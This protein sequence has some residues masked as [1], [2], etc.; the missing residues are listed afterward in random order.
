MDVLSESVGQAFDRIADQHGSKVLLS[1][2]EG[3]LTYAEAQWRSTRLAQYLRSNGL[4]G[5]E[6]VGVAS[7]DMALMLVAC[8]GI[9]KAGGAYVPLDPAL[10]D[11]RLHM[12]MKT[13]GIGLCIVDDV[14]LQ[15]FCRLA[16]AGFRPIR[17]NEYT[18]ASEERATDLIVDPKYIA[19]VLFTSGS[20]GTPKGVPRTHF[21]VLHNVFRHRDLNICSTDRVT[22]ITRNG[23]FDSVSNPY[24]AFLNGATLCGIALM[25]QGI[26]DFASWIRREKISVFY[27]FPTIFRQLA[28]TMPSRSDM[29]SIRLI[30]LGGEAVKGSDLM[31]CKTLLTSHAE[32]A[33][34]LNSTET[35]LT[36]L[37][38]MPVGA[39]NRNTNVVVGKPVPGMDVELQDESGR[40][41]ATGVGEIVIRSR[42]IFSGY[43]NADPDTQPRIYEDPAA[44]GTFVFHT[45][46]LARV[47]GAGRYSILG[48]SGQQIK[49]RGYRIE[50][51]EIEH[52]FLSLEAVSDAC[53]VVVADSSEGEDLAIAV[54]VVGRQDNILNASTLRE[55]VGETLPSYMVPTFIVPIDRL[56]QTPN[57][58][59]DRQALSLRMRQPPGTTPSGTMPSSEME[60]RVADSW[61]NILKVKEV[62]RESS[63]FDLGGNSI[64]ALRHI[65]HLRSESEQTIPIRLLFENP[66]LCAFCD[67]LARQFPR[68]N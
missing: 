2:A 31:I 22:L 6:V 51:G 3:E 29:K 44:R 19:H 11:H 64:K 46:D 67:A 49:L 7:N 55:Q 48:R 14:F 43:L 50:L 25:S 58:K 20:S 33:V 63:F 4:R 59:I 17:H 32:I 24:T 1:R 56:P 65:A 41:S 34:G 5:N 18:L 10:P 23:F 40:T 52:A 45:R 54:F 37:N 36:F 26:S 28:A 66:T 60:K 8:L 38:L 47:D 13:V 12:M 16:G 57:G 39:V 61:R 62:F 9:M 27:S 42:Y 68:G 30:Y 21:Q 35:G 15:R 53:A